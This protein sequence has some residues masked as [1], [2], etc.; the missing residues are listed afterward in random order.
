[1][2]DEVVTDEIVENIIRFI[3]SRI[4]NFGKRD[5]KLVELVEILLLPREMDNTF[6]SYGPQIAQRYKSLG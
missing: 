4:L 2:I 5:V 3:S 1:M 6:S